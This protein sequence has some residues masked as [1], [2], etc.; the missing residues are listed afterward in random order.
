[1]QS[2][3]EPRGCQ[4]CR[5]GG[6]GTK[7]GRTEEP[8]EEPT[9]G[10]EWP[11]LVPSPRWPRARRP[12]SPGPSPGISLVLP[13]VRRGEG[14]G[15]VPA[16]PWARR[17]ACSRG[18]VLRVGP[19]PHSPSRLGSPSLPAEEAAGKEGSWPWRSGQGTFPPS[20][21]ATGRSSRTFIPWYPTG[22]RSPGLPWN[23]GGSDVPAGAPGPTRPPRPPPAQ[24]SPSGSGLSPRP[25]Q[26]S[27]PAP[28]WCW[29]SRGLRLRPSLL[30][31]LAC[32]ALPGGQAQRVRD[33]RGPPQHA[34]RSAEAL[35][36]PSPHQP[37][38][39]FS[40]AE[41]RPSGKQVVQHR[42][43][44]GWCRLQGHGQAA[45]GP[46]KPQGARSPKVT[47]GLV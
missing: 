20:P 14:L 4:H 45:R 25:H 41:A 43:P 29:H 21:A 38:G 9:L 18:T 16:V 3:P 34:E 10:G 1:M 5:A 8:T 39:P 13:G 24:A 2:H 30:G 12:Q 28:A 42:D 46:Q 47:A 31:G 26:A 22:P 35:S 19:R 37:Q 40:G 36:S 7:D 27:T 33:Q 15:A 32:L 44:Q 17:H 11:A 23:R 6:P